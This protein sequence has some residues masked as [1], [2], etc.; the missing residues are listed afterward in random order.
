MNNEE[1][2]RRFREMG[3]GLSQDEKKKLNK[4]AL[5]FILSCSYAW[6][7]KTTTYIRVYQV[8]D[9]LYFEKT[10]QC[11]VEKRSYIESI[12]LEEYITKK[13]SYEIDKIT[14]SEDIP[15][16]VVKYIPRGNL[17]ETNELGS[18]V[19]AFSGGLPTLG[20]RR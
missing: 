7:K 1:L 12:T 13:F 9:D 19:H 5:L 16:K 2:Y 18:S 6:S 20:R 17:D 4:D 8:G 15:N 3:L 11:F 14:K 10:N